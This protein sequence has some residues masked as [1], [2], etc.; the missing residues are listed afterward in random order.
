MLFSRLVHCLN[1]HF[2]ITILR[3]IYLFICFFRNNNLFFVLKTYEN[4]RILN[5]IFNMIK[6]KFPVLDSIWDFIF[7][8]KKIVCMRMLNL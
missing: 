7:F 5:R 2:T 6:Y 4:L 3:V 8:M 1:I